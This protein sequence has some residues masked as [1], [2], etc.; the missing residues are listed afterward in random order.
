MHRVAETTLHQ[1]CRLSEGFWQRAPRESVAHPSGLWDATTDY[2]HHPKLLQQIHMQSKQQRN[3]LSSE[4]WRQ[5]RL[6]NVG[7]NIFN[8]TIDWVMRRTKEDQSR[9]IRWTLF[10]TP[11]DL[12]F[13]DDLALIFHTHQHMQENTRSREWHQEPSQQGQKRLQNAQQC[14]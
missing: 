7:F 2:R 10:S 12:D 4:D 5:T 8:M 14:V 3:Q 6:Y 9:G 13:A 11:E 1:L